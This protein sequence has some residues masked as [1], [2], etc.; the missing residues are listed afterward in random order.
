MSDANCGG[1]K[2]IPN[3][4]PQDSIDTMLAAHLL[5][6]LSVKRSTKCG[7]EKGSVYGSALAMPQIAR[8]AKWSRTMTTLALRSWLFLVINFV[9]QASILFMINQEQ[10]V[11][12]RFGGQMHLCDFGAGTRCPEGTGC[13]GPGGTVISPARTYSW[14]Q[15]NVRVFV[16]DSLMLVFPEKS[17]EIESQVDPGEYGMEDYLC[18]LAC[19]FIFMIKLMK[20]LSDSC[21]IVY[22]MYLVPSK[23]ESWISYHMPTW[24]EKTSVKKI[25]DWAEVDL[26]K[27]KV[28]GIPRCWKVINIIFLAVPKF[29]LWRA[30][31]TA[32]TTFLMETASIADMVVNSMAL[33]FI[34]TIDEMLDEHWTIASVQYMVDKLEPWSLMADEVDEG[35]LS[36]AEM[37]RLHKE[38]EMTGVPLNIDILIPR[39]V[40]ITLAVTAYFLYDYYTRQCQTNADGSWVSKSMYMPQMSSPYTVLNFLFPFFKPMATEDKPY[41]TMPTD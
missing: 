21:D 18:R 12:N 28:A 19:L 22:M 7:V 14:A 31:A 4:L 41:W 35:H 9:L 16:R 32:G 37:C 38:Y 33:T 24:A 5:A 40:I 39:R 20:S 34:L 15:W 17:D 2:D 13:V 36:E 6:S 30:T 29:L 23:A 25:R 3:E 26:V 8:S 1:N 11:W 27:L 10:Y